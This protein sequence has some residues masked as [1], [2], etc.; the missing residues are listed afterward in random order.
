MI[1]ERSNISCLCASEKEIRLLVK[2]IARQLCDE[3]ALAKKQGKKMT[4]ICVLSGAFMFFADL[5]RCIVG[6]DDLNIGFVVCKSYGDQS[7]SCGNVQITWLCKPELIRGAVVVF[8]DDLF[9]SGLTIQSLKE[10]VKQYQPYNVLSCTLLYKNVPRKSHVVIP[11]IIGKQ[12]DNKWVYGYGMDPYRELPC[13]YYK[14]PY[15]S[16]DVHATD[17][18]DKA[19]DVWSTYYFIMAFISNC[20]LLVFSII[21]FFLYF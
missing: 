13:I 5:I 1:L 4:L 7:V 14:C 20:L 19:L 17:V 18:V 9:D 21:C 15:P 12:V 11:D 3:H 2:N 8:V 16:N 10:D 6:V